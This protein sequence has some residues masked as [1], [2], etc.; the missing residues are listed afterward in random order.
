MHKG[1]PPNDGEESLRSV[2]ANV[3]AGL[4]WARRRDVP[5][6]LGWKDLAD[7]PAAT[8][9]TL[10]RRVS[11]ERAPG[12]VCGFPLPK[13]GKDE[14]RR[15][16]CLHPLDDLYLRLLV[17]RMLDNAS[18]HLH[19]YAFGAR[20]ANSPPGWQIESR[21]PE[22]RALR[23]RAHQMV[24]SGRYATLV[25]CDVRR[26]YPS[27]TAEVVEKALVWHGL[28]AKRVDPL[29][30]L[31]RG[32][33]LVGSPKGLPIR[34][35][36]SAVI[37]CLVLGVADRA[38]ADAGLAHLRYSDDCFIFVPHGA[39]PAHAYDIY[40]Q[41]LDSIG[42]EPNSDKY[43]EHSVEDGSA[44]SAV[45]DPTVSELQC[46]PARFED[47]QHLVAA[48]EE[49]L[50]RDEPNWRAVSFCI[51]GLRHRRSPYAL[52]QIYGD[53]R[54]LLNLPTQAG[55]YVTALCD[56]SPTRLKVDQDWLA[57][58]ATTDRGDGG[59]AAQMQM[60]RAASRV[61]LG[62][63]NGQRFGEIATASTDFAGQRLPLRAAASQAWAQSE[64]Y[65]Q[66][67]AEEMAHEFGHYDIRR[68]LIGSIAAKSQSSRRTRAFHQTMRSIDP[69]L[70]PV[71]EGLS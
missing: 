69:D 68:A 58:Q 13:P 22:W 19:R 25:K 42:L 8:C 40:G 32:L 60:C 61:R 62:K 65:K 3:Q 5:D 49:E 44:W 24:A 17:D 41:A 33:R 26:C 20:L 39:D 35:D 1:E 23:D 53:T 45:Q 37:A 18:F 56:H 12:A 29:V 46:G 47:T 54:V 11:E 38:L 21:N 31:L 9:R 16:A 4:E 70:E 28:D 10:G 66:R 14:L 52:P 6:V 57:E 48:L 50:D 63:S 36:S 2:E 34:P 67:R 15:L 71:L 64:S 7:H 43:E 55:R 30:R 27:I 59:L 51:G